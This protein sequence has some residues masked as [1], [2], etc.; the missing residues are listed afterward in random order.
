VLIDDDAGIRSALG[1]L[2]ALWGHP[3]YAGATV[4]D[5]LAVHA[6]AATDAQAPIGLIL[7]DYRL[8]NGVTGIDA[9]AAFRRALGTNAPAVLVTGDT[10]PDR[11]RA[12]HASGLC[13]LHKPIAAERLREL[14][15]EVG[16]GS[17]GGPRQNALC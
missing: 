10:A 13:V 5:V 15:A 17:I 4:D 7:A 6:T 11:L 1:G 8:G 14:I 16:A 12:L 2:L 3:V 9:V